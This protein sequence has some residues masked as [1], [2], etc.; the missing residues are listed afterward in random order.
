MIQMFQDGVEVQ[1]LPDGAKC[2]IEDKCP[3]EM[4]ECPL[5]K[6][7][8]KYECSPDCEYYTEEYG[9]TKAGEHE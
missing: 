1:V 3:F 2:I 4:E 6:C 9:N 5:W 7:E 8:S